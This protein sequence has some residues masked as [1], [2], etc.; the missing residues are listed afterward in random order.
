MPDLIH[1]PLIPRDAQ[2]EHDLRPVDALDLALDGERS[3]AVAFDRFVESFAGQLRLV[4]DVCGR[5]PRESE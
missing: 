1:Q 2:P 5:A 4:H 3:D